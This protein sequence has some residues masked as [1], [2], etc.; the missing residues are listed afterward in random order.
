MLMREKR[1][2]YIPSIRGIKDRRQGTGWMS[3]DLLKE[4]ILMEAQSLARLKSH[5]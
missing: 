3:G 5:A 2:D 4:C 1:M